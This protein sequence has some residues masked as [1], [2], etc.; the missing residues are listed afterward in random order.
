[1]TLRHQYLI[2]HMPQLKQSGYMEIHGKMESFLAFSLQK[3]HR[4]LYE[5]TNADHRLKSI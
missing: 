3:G 5:P 1:M 2:I 4:K